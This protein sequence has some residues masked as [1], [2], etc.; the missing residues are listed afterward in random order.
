MAQVF[1]NIHNQ[2]HDTSSPLEKTIEAFM[3][4]AYHTQDHETKIFVSP[5][6]IQKIIDEL[7]THKAPWPDKLT[8]E[9]LKNLPRTTIVQIYDIFKSCIH[10]S[11]FPSAWK[12]AV[13]P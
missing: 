13:H 1:E 9:K 10:L 8:S 12:I 2:A 7:P 6:L 11:Y 4:T 3:D 5:A